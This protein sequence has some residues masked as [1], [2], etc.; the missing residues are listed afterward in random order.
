M[1]KF[2]SQLSI[3]KK[4]GMFALGFGVAALFIGNPQDSTSIKVNVK[5]LALSTVKDKD[6]VSVYDLA[7]WIIKGSTDFTLVDLRDRKSFSEYNI[8]SSIN[9]QMQAL[10]NSNLLR[11]QKIILYGENDLS[12][13]QAWFILKSSGYKGVYILSGGLKAWKDKILF[14]KLAVNTSLKD[15]ARFNKIKE[16]SKFFGGTPQTS[17]TEGN[18]LPEIKMPKPEIPAMTNMPAKKKKREGC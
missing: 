10:L 11:N 7:D 16:V 2:F 1:K 15:S 14:P 18:N 13:A 12:A 9:I 5:E 6:L 17:S 4:L 8:P 3:A